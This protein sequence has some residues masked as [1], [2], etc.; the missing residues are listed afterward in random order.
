MVAPRFAAGADGYHWEE[1]NLLC[2]TETVGTLSTALPRGLT[3]Q[4]TITSLSTNFFRVSNR[5]RVGEDVSGASFRFDFV[6]QSKPSYL[7]IPAVSYNGNHWGQGNEPKGFVGKGVVRSFEYRRASIPGATYSE[8]ERH[9]VAM[10]GQEQ[11]RVE[12][13][14]F[15]CSLNPTDNQVTH[16]LI[17]PDEELPDCYSGRDVYTDGYRNHA[18]LKAGTDLTITCYLHVNRTQ[19]QHRSMRGFLDSAW[20]VAEKP[21]FPVPSPEQIWGLAMDYADHSLWREEGPY[22]GFGIGLSPNAAGG[23]SP[24]A[25]WKYEIGWCGNNGLFANAFLQDYLARGHK[26]SLAKALT[27]LDTW[28]TGTVLS[29]GLFITH[30]DNILDKEERLLDACNL[31]GAATS[32]FDAAELCARAGNERPGLRKIAFGICDFMVKDQQP[33]GQYGKAWK[34]NGECPYREG[35]IG[36]FLIPPVLEAYRMSQGS[37]LFAVSAPG[38]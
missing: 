33:S 13:L 22:K 8:G 37:A 16:S 21:N 17:Y 32:F 14:M 9:T 11:K 30:Y 23:F 34:Y 38:V 6:H 7:M 28:S 15:S 36:A 24:R 1:N 35:T 10:W 26:E 25:S 27:C 3:L 4:R 2:G 19:K 20:Q 18:S 29:N 31:G 12:D 5:I